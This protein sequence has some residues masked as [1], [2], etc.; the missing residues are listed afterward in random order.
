MTAHSEAVRPPSRRLLL[1]ER[2]AVFEFGALLGLILCS[3][4]AFRPVTAIP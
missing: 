3:V 2:R 4:A 1:G